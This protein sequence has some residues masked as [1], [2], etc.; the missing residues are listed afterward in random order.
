M[1]FD[2]L[3]QLNVAG[4]YRGQNGRGRDE[5]FSSP[6]AHLWTGRALQEN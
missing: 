6:P 4:V 1:R 3:S 5:D 2:Q